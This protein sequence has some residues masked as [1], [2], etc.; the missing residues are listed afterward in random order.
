MPRAS[1]NYTKRAS[2][3]RSILLSLSPPPL[4]LSIYLPRSLY[5]YH[6]TPPHNLRTTTH[7][8][9]HCPRPSPPLT[10]RPTYPA[11]N[12]HNYHHDLHLSR[13]VP[14]HAG[15]CAW[16]TS[17]ASGD[18]SGR[19]TAATPSS[20]TPPTARCS[21]G[22]RAPTTK[23]AGSAASP[24]RQTWFT[25][26][27]SWV[28]PLRRTG[29]EGTTS[30]AIASHGMALTMRCMVWCVAW[31]GETRG[32]GLRASEAKVCPPRGP[33]SPGCVESG[34]AVKNRG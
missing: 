24:C 33:R 19:S 25:G 26:E 20:S 5:N 31:V 8:R 29:K 32:G 28:R 3:F 7:E 30:T 9:T 4:S 23:A 21:S 14:T 6:A 34:G 11:P 15:G 1:L 2:S 27:P 10:P 18:T 13:A 22:P 17:R 16:R 12:H